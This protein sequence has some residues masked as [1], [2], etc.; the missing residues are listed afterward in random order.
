[1]NSGIYYDKEY[2][3]KLEIW[4]DNEWDEQ[5]AIDL[6][7][8][9]ELGEYN[10]ERYENANENEIC[11]FELFNKDGDPIEHRWSILPKHLL[12]VLECSIPNFHNFYN[13][14]GDNLQKDYNW[15]IYAKP[16]VERI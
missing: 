1:M 3:L 5:V 8:D 4:N 7:N 15:E 2:G 10:A 6:H 12:K 11:G 13:E 9:F 16:S 14:L